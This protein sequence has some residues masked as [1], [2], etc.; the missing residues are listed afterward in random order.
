MLF[1]K[2]LLHSQKSIN[3]NITWNVSRMPLGNDNGE[4]W[5][6]LAYNDSLYIA[7]NRLAS[8]SA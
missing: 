1:N 8:P 4:V 3:Y 7:T 6:D 5:T 2:I